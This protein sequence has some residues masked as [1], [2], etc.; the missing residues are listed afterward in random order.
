M[1]NFEIQGG[2]MPLPL[3]LDSKCI[4]SFFDSTLM[5]PHTNFSTK[6]RF[7]FEILPVSEKCLSLHRD[8]IRSCI[9]FRPRPTICFD[10][11]VGP[12]SEFEIPELTGACQFLGGKQLYGAPVLKSFLSHDQR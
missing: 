1:L 8:R 11:Q 3:H 10:P 9:W 12:C 5:M 2:A 4:L 6:I 7:C